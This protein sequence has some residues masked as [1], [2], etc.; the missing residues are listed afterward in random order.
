[1][2]ERIVGEELKIED[3][4]DEDIL[5]AGWRLYNR[6][7]GTPVTALRVAKDAGA[8][9]PTVQ[10]LGHV[11]SVLKK[12]FKKTTDV[13]GCKTWVPYEN[14]QRSHNDFHLY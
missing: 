14:V 12:E 1:M 2:E 4:R 13:W 7:P 6:F 3:I 5:K 10:Y 11:A 9:N 8:K